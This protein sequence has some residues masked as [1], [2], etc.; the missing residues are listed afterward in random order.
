MFQRVQVS[1]CDVRAWLIGK[2]LQKQQE[3]ILSGTG[4]VQVPS[5]GSQPE[6]RQLTGLARGTVDRALWLT[7]LFHNDMGSGWWG[8]QSKTLWLG[9]STVHNGDKQSSCR[10]WATLSNCFSC[11]GGDIHLPGPGVPGHQAVGALQTQGRAI[12]K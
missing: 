1:S 9:W 10:G 12:E 11:L 5:V 3:C 4:C 6:A 2:K 7:L 8:P